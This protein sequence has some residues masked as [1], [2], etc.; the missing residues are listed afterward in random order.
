[1]EF[2]MNDKLY[3]S[4]EALNYHSNVLLS[5]HLE[6][7]NHGNYHQENPDGGRYTVSSI[8]TKLEYPSFFGDDLMEWFS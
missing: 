8:S 3:H 5:N 4:E 1:M 6:S 2:C 7:S